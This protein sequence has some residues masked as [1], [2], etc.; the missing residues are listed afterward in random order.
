[1]G[2]G[3][4]EVGEHAVAHELGDVALETSDLGRDGVLVGPDDLAHLFGIQPRRQLSRANQ[5]AEEHG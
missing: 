1:M 5:V 4:A 2:F 3:V